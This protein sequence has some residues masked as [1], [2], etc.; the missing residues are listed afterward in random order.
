MREFFKFEEFGTNYRREIVG[1]ITTFL[2]MSY[3]IIVNPG[4]LEVAGI[5]KGPSTVATI[6][7]AVV[8]SML[9]AFYAKRPFAIAPYMGENAFIAFTVVLSLGYTW[10][11]GITSVFIG[12][13]IFV[14]ITIL[15]L[16]SWLANAVPPSLKYSF[17]VG[18]GLFLTFIGL[19]DTGIVIK[20]P[21]AGNVVPVMIGNLTSPQVLLALFSFFLMG[22][23]MIRKVKGSI[24]IGILVT[25]VLAYAAKGIGFSLPDVIYPDGFFS[26][27]PSIAPIAFQFKFAEVLTIGFLPILLSVFLMDFVDT[28]GTLIGVSARADFL[29]E[30]GNLPEIEKPMLADALATVVGACCGTTTTGTYIESA[31]GIEEGGRTG[32]TTFVTAILFLLALFFT[33][34]LTAVP[35]CAYGPALIIVGVLM[36]DSVKKIDFSDM[37]ELIPSFCT[38]ILMSFTYNLGIGIT[39]GLVAYPIVKLF[40]GRGREV[41]L[42]AWILGAISL[43]FYIFYPYQ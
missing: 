40:A 25:T 22:I 17:V 6:I 5:P 32:F 7:A 2:T 30:D 38:I 31:A 3:I 21:T 4:I 41:E 26:I 20:E 10:Q 8:G 13:L 9:M 11:A 16:R 33:P 12:G 18:I 24:M 28:M 36:I 14:V 34:I 27:P 37:T 23:L 35:K 29:D 1:G 39:A 19:I 15:G 43:I 42:G